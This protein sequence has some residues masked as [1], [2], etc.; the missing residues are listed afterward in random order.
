[1]V[2]HALLQSGYTFATGEQLRAETG[3]GAPELTEFLSHWD[4][5]GADPYLKGDYTFRYRRYGN[6]GLVPR[7][8]KIRLHEDSTFFQSSDIN[9]YAGDIERTFAPLTASLMGNELFLALLRTSFDRFG[10]EDEYLDA[11]WLLDVNLFR[12]TVEGNRVTEPTPE[13]IHRDG[14]PFGTVHV[15]RRHLVEGGVSH[16]YTMDEKLIDVRLLHEPLDTLYAFDDRVKHYATPIFSRG[17]GEGYRDTLV[18][19]FHLP[20]TKYRKG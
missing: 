2:N 10:V 20:D 7:T 3:F 4:D 1:M 14:V 9:P 8:G 19:G 12:L 11:E 5:L 13:G 18:Y 16:V 17:T 15:V 6:V